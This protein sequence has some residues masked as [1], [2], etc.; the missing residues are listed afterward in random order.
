MTNSSRMRRGIGTSVPFRGVLGGVGGVD[1][2]GEGGTGRER[3]LVRSVIGF[4]L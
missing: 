4:Q 3:K 1:C 2:S